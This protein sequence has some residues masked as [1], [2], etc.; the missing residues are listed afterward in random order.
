MTRPITRKTVQCTNEEC[1]DVAERGRPWMGQ[2][3]AHKAC[4]EPCPRCSSAVAETAPEE[5]ASPRAVEAEPDPHIID[6]AEA[7]RLL[8]LPPS[9]PLRSP[10]IGRPT[11]TV[12]EVR[13]GLGAHQRLEALARSRDHRHR[14]RE[15]LV[16]WVLDQW[17]A[18]LLEPQGVA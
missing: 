5:P 17:G 2:R 11:V 16:G 18:G 9:K 13:Y 7:A 4:E 8:A 1:P 10:F 6:E 12:G 15:E 3:K 14:S